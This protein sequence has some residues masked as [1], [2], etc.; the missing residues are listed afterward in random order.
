MSSQ[1]GTDSSLLDDGQWLDEHFPLHHAV[2][3]NDVSRLG[4]LLKEAAAAAAESSVIDREDTHGNTAMHIGCMLGHREC[5]KLLLEHGAS[6]Q[7]GNN[8]G[9]CSFHEAISYGD[10]KTIRMM[11]IALKK[12]SSGQLKSRL[13]LL[14]EHFSKLADFYMETKW[15]FSSWIPLLSRILPSDTFKIYK[16]GHRLRFDFSLV[17]FNN[18]GPLPKWERG[19]VS[20]LLDILSTDGRKAVLMD[21]RKGVYQVLREKNQNLSDE[22]DLLITS[23]ITNTHMS[24]KPIHFVQAKNFLNFPKW[25]KIDNYKAYL[26]HIKGM[27]LITMKRR[28][29]LSREDLERNKKMQLF[30]T[31]GKMPK[32]DDNTLEDTESPEQDLKNSD[33]DSSNLDDISTDDSELNLLESLEPPPRPK[34]SWSNYLRVSDEQSHLGR[35][36]QTKVTTKDVSGMLAMSTDFPISLNLALDI[37]SVME[38]VNP[39]V[40]K[41]REFCTAKLPEGFPVRVEMPIFATI[42]ARII[43]Q[44]FRWCG[45]GASPAFPD[46]MFRIPDDYREDPKRFKRM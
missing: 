28:E 6:V 21:N 25:D 4:Q 26:F 1:N 18:N 44:Q 38:P 2:F 12:Q 33:A 14:G 46:A 39:T 13:P 30:F 31:S 8:L 20:L 19:D 17:D 42:Q 45:E 43:F 23:D 15:E 7:S 41:L 22:L 36:I 40:A 34:I 35:P 32:G 3:D 10:R 5:I 11:L 27:Q 16:K 9:W 37:L 24:T 29:H